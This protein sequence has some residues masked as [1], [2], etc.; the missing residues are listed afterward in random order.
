MSKLATRGRRWHPF[1]WAVTF[2]SRLSNVH[3]CGFGGASRFLSV[4]AHRSASIFL[5]GAI[6][7][8]PQLTVDH[9]GYCIFR[10]HTLTHVARVVKKEKTKAL[11]PGMVIKL[12][13]EMLKQ[14][15]RGSFGEYTVHTQG[16]HSTVTALEYR[17]L[18]ESLTKDRRSF[19]KDHLGFLTI[20]Q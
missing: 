10:S 15:S 12:V 8:C 1:S 3:A 17:K 18:S 11:A 14:P 20:E 16:V 2:L 5:N 9:T 13:G 7:K 4:W 6:C 19:S